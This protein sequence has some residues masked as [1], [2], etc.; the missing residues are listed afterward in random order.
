VTAP[1]RTLEQRQ[2]DTKALLEREVDCWVATAD[3]AT[4][5]PHL[6]PLSFLWDGQTLLI[7]TPAAS[8]TG[9]NL[10][11]GRARLGLGTTRDVV[12]MEGLVE[13]LALDAVPVEVADAFAIK[14]GFDPRRSSPPFLFFRIR[15]RRV[16]AWREENEL[17]G[18]DLMR[19]GEWLATSP[20]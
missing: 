16:Q 11:S 15:P 6:V 14:T 19:D 20:G 4:C 1:P 10:A 12:L 7:A 2:G 8:P 17:A 9:R 18:R 5:A 13:K 3:P